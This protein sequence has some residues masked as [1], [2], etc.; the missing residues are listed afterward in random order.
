VPVKIGKI[1]DFLTGKRANGLNHCAL[2][3]ENE[4]DDEYEEERCITSYSYSCSSSS[5]IM[6]LFKKVLKE[7][8]EV[9]HPFADF[10][11]QN[12]PELPREKAQ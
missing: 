10:I 9:R 12:R 8:L 5:S 11:S 2:D 7:L 3:N 4:D 6:S 1:S